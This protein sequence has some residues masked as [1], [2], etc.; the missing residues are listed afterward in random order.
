MGIPRDVAYPLPVTQVTRPAWP[1]GTHRAALPN[2]DL[3]GAYG[4]SIPAQSEQADS[5]SRHLR[6][7]ESFGNAAGLGS[8]SNCGKKRG[9]DEIGKSFTQ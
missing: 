5:T 7:D 9:S 2:S 4:Q 1:L 3:R 8:R 6:D